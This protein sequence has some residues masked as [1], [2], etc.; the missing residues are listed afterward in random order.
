MKLSIGSLLALALASDAKKKSKNEEND[1]QERLNEFARDCDV[2]EGDV[3]PILIEQKNGVTIISMVDNEDTLVEFSRDFWCE[4][5]QLVQ[6]KVVSMSGLASP[7][8]SKYCDSVGNYL[9]FEYRE[10]LKAN[11]NG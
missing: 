3:C 2:K 8:D 4:Y 1:G 5:G 7:D 11:L 6:I 9:G 10:R